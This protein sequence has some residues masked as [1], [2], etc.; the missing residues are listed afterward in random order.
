MTDV[1]WVSLAI[2]SMFLRYLLNKGVHN[3]VIK[4]EN[5]CDTLLLHHSSATAHTSLTVEWSQHRQ[6]RF[7][8]EVRG[9]VRFGHCILPAW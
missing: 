7:R 4:I 3:T 6:D 1:K 8:P 2:V 5:V 9:I